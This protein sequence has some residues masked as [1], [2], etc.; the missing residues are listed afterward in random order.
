MRPC[1]AQWL[2]LGDLQ[3][4]FCGSKVEAVLMPEGHKT[5]Y[6]ARQHADL[7]IG[8]AI[9][10]SSPQ[11]RFADDAKRVDGK[12]LVDVRAA[13]KHLFYDF[14]S[15]ETVHVHLGRYGTFRLDTLP[16]PPPRGQV[17]MRM[18]FDQGTIDL[19]GPSQ[20]RVIGPEEV[21]TI[22][23]GLGPDPLAGGRR[24]DV[25]ATIR[26]SGKPIA[27]LLLDQSIMAGV[28]NIFRAEALFEA[29]VH[30]AVPGNQLDPTQFTRIWKALLRMMK[31]GLKHGRIISVTRSEVDRPL[32]KLNDRQRFRVYACDHCGVCGGAI[33]TESIASRKIYFCPHCQSLE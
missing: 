4:R 2:V 27:T 6:L 19:N 20:C 26:E 24:Q 7:L 15:E 25:W 21:R 33:A 12:T 10:V 16:P 17:R 30:P 11:G 32:S 31:V 5:H 23:R 22:I 29:K 1:Q 8:K 9:A 13:G 28:G 14:E 18:V 3:F